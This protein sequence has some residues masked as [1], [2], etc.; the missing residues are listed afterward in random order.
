MSPLHQLSH[1]QEKWG[2]LWSTPNTTEPH[3][4]SLRGQALSAVLRAA[5]GTARRQHSPTGSRSFKLR[6]HVRD[7]VRPRHFGCMEGATV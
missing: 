3:W 2:E 6:T 7:G 4:A 5:G 1:E